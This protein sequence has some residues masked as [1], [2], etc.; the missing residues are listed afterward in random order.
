LNTTE[1]LACVS[2]PD[3]DPQTAWGNQPS[4]FFPAFLAAAHRFFAANASRFRAAAPIGFL[5]PLRNGIENH[6]STPLA[7][8]DLPRLDSR[9]L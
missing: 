7:K 1:A 4:R 6:T 2:E 5:L 3:G 8:I 9:L